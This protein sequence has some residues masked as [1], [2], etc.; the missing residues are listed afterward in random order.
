M[1]VFYFISFL[2]VIRTPS[3]LDAQE[4]GA[5]GGEPYSTAPVLQISVVLQIWIRQF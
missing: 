2:H 1:I 3:P 4:G 5:E